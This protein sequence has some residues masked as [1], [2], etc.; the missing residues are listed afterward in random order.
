MINAYVNYMKAEKMSEN[1]MRGYTNHINQMLNMVNKPESDITYLDLVNWKADISSLASATVANKV[2]AIKSY[3]GFLVN[4]QI[5]GSDPS[6]NLSRPTNIKNKEK[7]Y[8]SEDD[9]K[10][11]VKFARTPRDKAIFKFLLST[12]VRFCEMANITIEQYKQAIES[13]RTIELS[14]TKG[15]KGGKIFINDSTKAAIDTYLRIRDDEC[16]YLFASERAHKLSDNSVSHTI[17]V[18]ARRAGLPYWSDLSCHGLR[19]ACATIMNDKNV[20]VGTISKVLRHS[21]LSVT[22]RYIKSSQ[23]NI[24]NATALMEF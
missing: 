14:V 5:I 15:D 6:Q 21:S 13:D 12:G 8:V 22:T 9:A 2:A 17:K 23:N 16:P 10:M 4:A 11:L 3:F 19:A 18:A 1:T 7:P 24:N 20:P